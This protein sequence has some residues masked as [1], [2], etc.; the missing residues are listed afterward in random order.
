ME[1]LKCEESFYENRRLVVTEYNEKLFIHIREYAEN[2]GRRYP[3]RKGI[4]LNMQRLNVLVECLD[5]IDEALSRQRVND[6]TVLY[7]MHLGGGVYVRVNE[8]FNGVDF[9]RFWKPNGLE[10]PELPTKNGIFIPTHQ[11][12]E[13][14]RCIEDLMSANPQIKNVEACFHQN[15]MGMLECPECSPWGW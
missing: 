7:K 8:K 3:T 11:W 9:R 5:D 12:I 4:S 13:L 15:Q 10:K 14:R 1:T 6:A 2:N